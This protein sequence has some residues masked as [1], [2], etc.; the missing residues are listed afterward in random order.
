[1]AHKR[2][3]VV[4]DEPLM[5]EFISETLRR[6]KYEVKV[7]TDGAH[8]LE[9]LNS[10][11]AD[12][13]ISDI[14]MPKMNGM[15]LLD[16]LTRTYPATD[17]IM[18]TAYGTV[19]DAVKAIKKGA[20]DYIQKPFTAEELAI[21]VNKVLEF[22]GLSE[23]NRFLRKELG[24]KFS[25]NQIVGVCP[26]MLKVF[27]AMDMV[28][29]SKA[30]VLIQG[31]SGTGKELVARAIHVN[32]PR[33]NGPFIKINCAAMPE[34]LMESELF[35][36]EK[37]A[38]TG[39]IK[40]TDGRFIQAHSGTLLL[41]EIAEMSQ[42]MQ[43]KLL[44]VL[45]E[46]EF[47]R[48]GGKETIK[49]DV[50][51]IATTNRDLKEAIKKNE[52]R[53]DLYYRLNVFPIHMPKL[54]ERKGDI[55]LL[56]DHFVKKFSNE[57]NR[58]IRGVQDTAIDQLM[59]Y[60]W[61]G[62]VRELE[63]KLERAV[64]LCDES[65]IALKHLFFEEQEMLAA[66][67]P[68][69]EVGAKTLRDIEKNVILKTLQENENNRTRTAETLGISIRTLRNKLREYRNENQGFSASTTP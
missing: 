5:R 64:I 34:T 66:L 69:T 43:A 39:A 51:I 21:K 12:L 30:T 32:G 26:K 20:Y 38:F 6:R 7:A 31:D 33:K 65:M 57:Y 28:I 9:Q 3:L 67:P 18:I 36:H 52:F 8:A 54:V 55:P 61:P 35:G 63:N 29:E 17:V 49:V 47:E 40:T 50:R 59:R 48:V 42:Q 23:E 44:R 58:E 15:E 1:M 53:E 13:V 25:F 16:K 60:H 37:G 27:E 24:G 22:R 56:I 46:K 19:D 62:N 14:K 11:T 2:I 41:D 4:D 10:W 68:I 45:Q